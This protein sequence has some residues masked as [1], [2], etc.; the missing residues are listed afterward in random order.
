METMKDNIAERETM[1]S[2]PLS[3]LPMNL[4]LEG[5][6]MRGLYT[7]G[8]LDFFLDHNLH[9]GY[10][11]GVSAGACQAT[12]YIS[13]QKGRSKT[14]NT[15]FLD[16]WRYMSLRSF[17]LTGS[18]FGMK[19]LFDDIPN[20]LVP[21]DYNTFF[22]SPIQLE[23]GT[24]DCRTG[25]SRYF[26]KEDL[27]HECT[28]LRASCSLPLISPVVHFKDSPLLDGGIADPI[29]VRRALQ[30]SDDKLVVILTQ[31]RGYRKKAISKFERT[32]LH[33][34]YRKY[35]AFI[36]T[37][38]KRHEQYNETLDLLE[39]LESKGK[40]IVFRPSTPL[41]V[42]RYEKNPAKLLALYQ[43]GYQDAEEIYARHF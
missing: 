37:V 41:E 8:V 2:A 3:L 23:I 21:F 33:L 10:V 28:V 32:M 15:A 11:V 16:D 29:P 39:T 34:A 24:T 25:A 43:R 18:Y 19:F 35:P 42:D 5:G 40:A 4:V 6:G 30:H 38:L 17:L 1:S 27:D 22:E 14:T 26:T 36:E 20:R 7:S 13:R 9:F 31:N 12:S